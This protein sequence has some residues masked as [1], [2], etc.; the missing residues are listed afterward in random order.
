MGRTPFF[1]DVEVGPDP[2]GDDVWDRWASII[3]MY[4]D[5]TLIPAECYGGQASAANP[6]VPAEAGE[7]GAICSED[8]T[9]TWATSEAQAE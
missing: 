6:A 3:D 7:R 2:W 1:G 5:P 9:E 4:V 8:A